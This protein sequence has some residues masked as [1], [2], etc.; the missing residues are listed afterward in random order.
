MLRTQK[1]SG[2]RSYPRMSRWQDLITPKIRRAEGLL[3]IFT[4]GV[5][6]SR[7]TLD[8]L[9]KAAGHILQLIGLEPAGG[10]NKNTKNSANYESNE[11]FSSFLVRTKAVTPGTP[12]PLFRGGP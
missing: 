12:F 11:G 7:Q 2:R 6:E 10:F 3:S 4:V 1:S 9:Y 5:I 8:N